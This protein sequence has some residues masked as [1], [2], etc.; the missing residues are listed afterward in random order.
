[1]ARKKVV[2]AKK[3][4]VDLMSVDIEKNSGDPKPHSKP[5]LHKLDEILSI[6]FHL[7]WILIGTFFLLLIVGQIRQGALKS[8]LA[9]SNA[10]SP[11]VS[12]APTETELPGVGTV[13]IE[14][15]KQALTTETIQK[16]LQSGD[17]STLTVDEKSKLDPC[18]VAA[19]SPTPSP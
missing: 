11:D 19:E 7:Q 13:N 18:I 5:I 3:T 12:Q 6:V 4:N 15:I 9:S 10:G 2:S 8:I 17:T 14:C 1:M 16:I